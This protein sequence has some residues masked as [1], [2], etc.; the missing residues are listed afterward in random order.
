MRMK[1][2]LINKRSDN[3][4]SVIT[5]RIILIVLL[6]ILVYQFTFESI[7]KMNPINLN[8]INLYLN[9]IYYLLCFILDLYKK[10]TKKSYQI[11]NFN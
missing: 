7:D 9:I 4:F 10:D 2:H 1:E 8:Q 3:R 5:H 6:I 11:F